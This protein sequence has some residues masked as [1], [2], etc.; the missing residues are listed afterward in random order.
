VEDGS[1]GKASVK[2]YDVAGKTGTA[3]K[4]DPSTGLYYSDRHVA[5]FCGFVPVEKPRLSILVL[6]D[7]PRVALDTGGA[8]AAPVFSE[9]AEASLNYLRVPPNRP[10]TLYVKDDMHGAKPHADAKKTVAEAAVPCSAMPDLRGMSK[11]QVVHALSS[12]QLELAFKGSGYA[13]E[14]SLESGRPVTAGAQ[15]TIVFAKD[16]NADETLRF[17]Q[18]SGSERR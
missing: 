7:S 17:T 5:I 2:G 15:C 8:V 14:Q 13:V 12:L 10:G 16:G 6:V 18:A 11:L 9:I 1:G 3:Q 4:M